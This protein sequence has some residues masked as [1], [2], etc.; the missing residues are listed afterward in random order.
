MRPNERE[1][2]LKQIEYVL[3]SLLENKVMMTNGLK[4]RA[5]EYAI[6]K[7]NLEIAN[8]Y[9]S[10]LSNQSSTSH[11]VNEEYLKEFYLKS[12]KWDNLDGIAH[13]VNYSRAHEVSLHDYKLNSFRPALDYYLNKKFNLNKIMTFLKFYGR[14]YQDKFYME[15]E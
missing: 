2:T 8:N 5:C 4:A 6:M 13:L 3:Q 12:L 15:L 9:V 7:G 1:D 10:D 14:F 11:L